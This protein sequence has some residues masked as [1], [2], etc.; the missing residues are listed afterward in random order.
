M[1]VK[2]TSVHISAIFSPELTWRDIQHLIAE[3]ARIVTDDD[4]WWINGANFHVNDQFGFG[5]MDA[6]RMVGLAQTWVNKPEQHICPTP[7][8]DE[9]M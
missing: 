6:S 5:M 9:H 3:T 7:A 4:E 1:F 2:T 8:K